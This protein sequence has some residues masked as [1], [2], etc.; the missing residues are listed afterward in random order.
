M[1]IAQ[2]LIPIGIAFLVFLA[3]REV[4]CW[5]FKINKIL[6]A[7]NSIDI[8]LK[9]LSGRSDDYDPESDVKYS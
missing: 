9:K 2:M 1:D 8:S 4:M 7:L 5:Y 6:I 3:I